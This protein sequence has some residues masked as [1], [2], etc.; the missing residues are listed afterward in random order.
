MSPEKLKIRRE[1]DKLLKRE[2]RKNP[3]YN[4]KQLIIKKKWRQNNLEKARETVRKWR[5]KNGF[6][7]PLKYVYCKACGKRFKQTMA[8]QIYCG[9]K[10][11][12]TGCSY[13]AKLLKNR[14]R[15][16][17]EKNVKGTHTMEEWLWLCSMF[18]NKCAKCGNGNV[19]LTKDHIIPLSKGGTNDIFNIQPLCQICNSK[20]NNKVENKQKVVFLAAVCDLTHEGH[21][22]LFKKMR[23][24]GKKTIVILHDDASVFRIKN[25]IP[26]QNLEQRIANVKLTELIDEVLCTYSEE[27]NREFEY[28]VKRYGLENIEYFRGDDLTQGFPGQWYLEQEGVKI[29]FLPYT[30]GVS[31][32]QIRDEICR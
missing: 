20:K 30:K 19:K 17:L 25:K 10:T 24:T 29:T 2:L 28:I 1:K 23:E 8:L 15:F 13:N 11:G 12:K 7:E 31:S 21:F 32:T 3:E 18:S 22:N 14:D 9:S 26:I 4:K 27:P 5:Y 16:L 6:C